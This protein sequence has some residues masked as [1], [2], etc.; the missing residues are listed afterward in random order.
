MLVLVP[1]AQVQ[2]LAMSVE[3]GLKLVL[4]GGIV[5]SGTITAKS[6]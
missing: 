3:D 1:A 2:V 5:S 6:S 4:S